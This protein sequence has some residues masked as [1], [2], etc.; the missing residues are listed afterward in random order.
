MWWFRFRISIQWSFCE[1]GAKSVSAF[2]GRNVPKAIM[3]TIKP[4]VEG[5]M[6]EFCS[7]AISLAKV[8]FSDLVEP[9]N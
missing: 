3:E 7:V 1:D 6:V 5:A 8:F 4:T 9:R 2:R